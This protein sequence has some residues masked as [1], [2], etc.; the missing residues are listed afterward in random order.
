[1]RT[2]VVAPH[3]DD[4]LLGVGGS[5]RRRKAEGVEVFWLIVTGMTIKHGWSIKKIDK[6]AQEVK[7]YL[8]LSGLKKFLNSTFQLHS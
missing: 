7:K 5:I 2:I 3:P 1:M 6:R 4:E 8:M